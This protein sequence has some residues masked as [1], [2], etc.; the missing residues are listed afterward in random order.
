MLTCV[1]Y[2]F[3]IDSQVRRA[4]EAS[5]DT[6]AERARADKLAEEVKMYAARLKES[7]KD[8]FKLERKVEEADKAFVSYQARPAAQRAALAR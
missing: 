7:E 6:A 2:Q 3:C 5:A 4:A 1:R 8:V